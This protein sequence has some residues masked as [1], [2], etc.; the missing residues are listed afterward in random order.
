MAPTG[1][2]I[3]LD[4]MLASTVFHEVGH[5][6]ACRYGGARPGAMGCGV[7]LVW[8]AFYTDIT[9]T[10]RLGRAGR[11]RADL[12]GVYFN[13]VFLIAMALL[14]AQ[15]GYPPLLVAVLML[16][17]EIMQQLLPTLRFDGY[18]IVADLVGAS[19]TC[20]PTSAR[21]SNGPCCAANPTPG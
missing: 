5:A 17:L 11:L 12:G 13:A 19:P 8:P 14:Y 2:L 7:Y 21:S 10:Y 3:V 1:I 6:T 15:T 4:L 16:N 9:D 20:S 18:Y